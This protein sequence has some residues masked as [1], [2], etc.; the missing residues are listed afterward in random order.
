MKKRRRD[1]ALR[2]SRGS[3]MPPLSVL[4]LFFALGV[5]LGFLFA[6]EI[7]QTENSALFLYMEEYLSAVR[8][9]N[10]TLPGILP[11][12]WETFRWPLLVVLLSF[13]AIG[14]LG[15]PVVFIV[16]GFLLSFAVAA[17]VRVFGGIG[18]VLAFLLFGITGALSVPVLFVLGVQGMMAC[19]DLAM[20]LTG[21]KRG[22]RI[23]DRA[24]WGRYGLC[25]FLLLCCVCLELVVVPSLLMAL[26]WTF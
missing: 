21:E 26:A 19:R 3:W 11:V 17:F 22:G 1:R 8:N 12:L 14:F 5:I 4:C 25:A 23:Y 6:K 24:Y 2:V 9:G 7:S 13:T 18:V 10:F 20:G 15:I 16:R